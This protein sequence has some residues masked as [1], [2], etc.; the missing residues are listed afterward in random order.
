MRATAPMHAAAMHRERQEKLCNDV[1]GSEGTVLKPLQL[2][3]VSKRRE[4]RV[5][6]EVVSSSVEGAFQNEHRG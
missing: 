4:S 1:H 5:D 2:E 3:R 6:A